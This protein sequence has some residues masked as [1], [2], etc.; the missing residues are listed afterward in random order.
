MFVT[1]RAYAR[2]ASDN[3]CRK[4]PRTARALGFAHA[5]RRPLLR[6][7]ILVMHVIGFFQSIS[8]VMETRT[9]QGAIA[10]AISLNTIPYIA[11]PA[12]AIFGDGDFEDYVTT[13]QEGLEEFRPMARA[14]VDAMG[15]YPPML[16][17]SDNQSKSGA[18]MNTMSKLSS[19]PVTSG[20]K[21]ELLIDGKETFDSIFEAIDDA[22][23]YIL[24]QFYIFR[25]DDIGKQLKDKLISKA[26]KGV[27]VYLLYDNYGSLGVDEKYW[28]DMRVAG[29]EVKSF[30][31]LGD[32]VNRFQLNYR[33]HR[34]LVVVDGKTAFVGGLN[35]GD[36]YL[37]KH[38]TLTPW[39]DTCARFTGPIVTSL[40]VPFAEDWYWATGDVLELIGWD[41]SGQ[42]AG[43]AEAVCVPTGPA[44]EMDTCA[45]HFLA[46][47]EGAKDRIWI[48]TPYFVPD[49]AIVLALQ[50]AAKRGVEVRILMPELYDSKLVQYS[51]Y[52]YLEAMDK[53]GAKVW[54]FQKGFL[55]QKILLVDDDFVSIGSA[56][57]DNRSFRLNFELQVA[58]RDRVFADEVE[59]MLVND[60]SNAR[61][62][63]PSELQSKSATFKLG[64]R[65][66]RLLA[67]IQ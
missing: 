42:Q 5:K 58:V 43:A 50:L 35:V 48:A 30:M 54:R 55:H 26:R 61:P 66:S 25:N 19:L 8:A 14:L 32:D 47:I 31:D 11:V 9:P 60:F 57:L 27:R 15:E 51:S 46:A 13:R 45:L 39:R 10:W 28:E 62:T 34:K 20:N 4:F 1:I 3:I 49:E 63:G 24:V 18:L 37:G 64:V 59:K 67:P 6:I 36:E 52:S 33:N 40:Q 41:T 65:I 22:D 38:A 12:Y 16:E 23:T 21:V 53:A 17:T 29:A 2:L 44:D 7:F 56:N